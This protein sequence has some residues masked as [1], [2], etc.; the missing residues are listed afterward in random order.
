M[1]FGSLGTS[2]L[3]SV[4]L[5]LTTLA[6]GPLAG[7]DVGWIA[8]AKSPGRESIDWG[9][10]AGFTAMDAEAAA[11]R[12]CARMQQFSGECYLVASGPNCAAVAWDVSEPL[13]IAFGGVGDTPASAISAA[14]AAAGPF[15]NAP[16]VRCSYLARG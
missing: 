7:A 8:V 10:G 3:V 15:A 11:L 12:L 2:V 4:G 6:F 1:S 13:N 16:E 5:S 9:G 14:V